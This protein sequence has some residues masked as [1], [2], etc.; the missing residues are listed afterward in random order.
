MGE[1]RAML[2]H[3]KHTMKIHDSPFYSYGR[4]GRELRNILHGM[5]QWTD[6]PY[7]KSNHHFH[8]SI[9]ATSRWGK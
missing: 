5:C 2:C 8:Y 6:G 1:L 9:I 4:H 7:P 3:N